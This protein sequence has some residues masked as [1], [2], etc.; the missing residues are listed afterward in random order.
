MGQEAGWR[1]LHVLAASVLVE[2]EEE[3]ATT[4]ALDEISPSCMD[5]GA[6]ADCALTC[7]T[8]PGNSV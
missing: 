3:C 4:G 2:G 7:G 8:L 5:E 6:S 1:Q